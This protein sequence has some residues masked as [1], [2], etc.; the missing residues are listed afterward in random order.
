MTI[1]RSH[2][3]D[4]P[5]PYMNA[6]TFAISNPNNTPEDYPILID[7]ITKQSITFGQWKHDTR[8]WA[9]ALQRNLNFKRGDVLALFSFNQ[10]DYS[11]T[12]FGPLILAGITTTVNS[13]YNADELAYQ[14]QDSGATVMITHP[15]L[16]AIARAGAKKVG[17]P[18]E[19]IFLYGDRTVDGFRPYKSLLPPASTPESQLVE[20]VK[21]DA[22]QAKET[23]ALICYS[24]GT[25][26]RSKGVELSHLNF[27][28]NAVQV[29]AFDGDL[30]AHDNVALSVLPMYHMYSIQLHLMCGPY[31]GLQNIVLQKFNP[32]DF[33]KTIQDYKIKTLNLVP[34]QVLMLVK[35]PLVANYDLS[36][37]RQ[38]NVGAAPCSR[39][40]IEALLEKFPAIAFRQAYGMSEAS[41]GTH[42]GLYNDMVHGSAGKILPNQ[43]V[44]LVDPD[45]GKDAAR[46]E[47]GEIWIR[48]LNVMKGYRNN[49]KATR[50]TIDSE[51]WLHTGDV[52]IVDERGNFFVVDRLKELIK[53]KGFQV[54]PAELEAILLTHPQILD[55]AVIGVENKEQATEV[56]LAF[57]VKNK[58]TPE[59]NALTEQQ[60]VDYVTSKVA[61][62]KKLRG[63]V[64]FIDLI[65]KSAAGKILRKDLRVLLQEPPKSKL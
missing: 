39:E 59:G 22:I 38:I 51:G 37:V 47:R 61:Q 17:L 19:R 63:G 13:A 46:G 10:I 28:I 56:P 23:T 32:E 16:L 8:R 3:P 12:M 1:Y 35:S 5:V 53:Y 6:Y 29:V 65:P 26:G 30:H 44:R 34:P 33:L 58:A 45:T 4:Q 27:A 43:E 14:L 49:E 36:H 50:E 9:T 42:V 64:R 52:G 24:S 2:I 20:P 21:L 18:E 40:L 48:G 31:S 25:T 60:V 15:E 54:A 55:A 57:V 11:L 62:H 7:G 41:P